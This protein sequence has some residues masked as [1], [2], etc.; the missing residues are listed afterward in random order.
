MNPFLPYK[1]P[2]FIIIDYRVDE[3]ILNYFK[4][5]NIKII[6]TIKCQ[7]L[8]E[9]VS[10]H[11]DMILHPI[12]YGTVIIAPNVFDYYKDILTK[13]GI[14]VIKGEKALSRN[15]PEDIAYNVARVGKYALH[16]IKYTDSKL[17]YYLEKAGNEF[18]NVNQ[19]YT[20]CST[21]TVRDNAILTS[22]VSIH[23][24]VKQ[25]GIQS[26]YIKPYDIELKGF[27]YGFIG[28][29]AGAL[30]Q[31]CFILTG[32]FKDAEEF[33]KIKIFTQNKGYNIV[34]VSNEKI[35]DLGTIIPIM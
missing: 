18:L 33:N 20:K 3:E 21:A 2:R 26:I 23:K 25:K 11:P 29:A 24:K 1:V 19:G 6:K 15:Y 35:T 22:D 4:K 31:N 8:Q 30:T 9:P 32:K 12:D 27:N 10:G 28:G 16:N 34:Q 13:K 5:V 17:K 7:E 14:K